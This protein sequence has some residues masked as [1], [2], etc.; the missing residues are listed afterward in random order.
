MLVIKIEERM[1]RCFLASFLVA[2]E[3]GIKNE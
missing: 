2:V 3:M 1:P